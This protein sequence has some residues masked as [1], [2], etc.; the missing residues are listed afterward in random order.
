M[1]A[2]RNISDERPHTLLLIFKKMLFRE[3]FFSRLFLFSVA[4]HSQ[5]PIPKGRLTNKRLETKENPICAVTREFG[6]A[7]AREPLSRQNMRENA[8]SSPYSKRPRSREFG[9]AGGTLPIRIRT[10]QKATSVLGIIGNDLGTPHVGSE[11]LVASCWLLA[12][13]PLASSLR[14][15]CG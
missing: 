9:N 12:K 8:N 11:L 14:P 13:D 15:P 5:I 1:G 4:T 2:S 10:G 6:N 7:D 3:I